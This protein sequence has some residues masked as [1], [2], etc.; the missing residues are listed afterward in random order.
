V[1]SFCRWWSNGECE[2]FED[3]RTET[4]ELDILNVAGVFL[5]LLIG[6]LLSAVAGFIEFLTRLFVR[7]RKEVSSRLHN[8]A[9]ISWK[10]LRVSSVEDLSLHLVA[11]LLFSFSTVSTLEQFKFHFNNFTLVTSSCKHW[12]TRFCKSH[13]LSSSSNYIK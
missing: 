4:K 8:V 7:R 13:S 12:E 3:T 5:V 10:H 1:V 6:I 2:E 11:Y 9:V